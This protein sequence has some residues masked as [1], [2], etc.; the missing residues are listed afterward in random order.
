MVFLYLLTFL[1]TALSIF[2]LSNDFPS[3]R[4]LV[5][6][7]L[8]G[9]SLSWWQQKNN[10]KIPHLQTAAHLVLIFITIKALIPFFIDKPFDILSGLIKTWVYFLILASFIL[11][12]KRNFYLLQ[13]FS[14]GLVVFSCFSKTSQAIISLGYIMS[15]FILWILTLRSMSL[16]QDVKNIKDVVQTKRWMQ[17]ELIICITFIFLM[18]ILAIPVYLSIPRLNLPV[19]LL[20]RLVKQKYALTY[21]DFPKDTLVSFLSPSQEQATEKKKGPEGTKLDPSAL[22]GL[23][24]LSQEV[25]KPV[26]WHGPAKS[27]EGYKTIIT[28]LNE[29]IEELNKEI[30]K[31]NS[32]LSEIS[33]NEN[34][35]QLS[36]LMEERERL[37]NRKQGLS[38]TKNELQEERNALKKEF[39][40]QAK[41]QN[42]GSLNQLTEKTQLKHLE[43]QLE[44]VQ[45]EIQGV[46][47]KLRMIEENLQRAETGIE[48]VREN[49]NKQAKKNNI[50]R[51]VMELWAKKEALEE[52]MQSAKEA[53]ENLEAEYKLYQQLVKEGNVPAETESTS[54]QYEENIKEI[55]KRME[56]NNKQI[57]K[58]EEQLSVIGEQIQNPQLETLINK[59]NQVS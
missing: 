9:L 52:T 55:Q 58:I 22:E 33:E 15:F 34:L 5:F 3:L 40:E 49:V 46:I 57:A 17:R 42:L 38:K 10:K 44:S 47:N 48:E 37:L 31:A 6:F 13:F 18:I 56:E 59:I 41:I 51:Q 8:I 53:Q 25:I 12:T 50:H 20:F 14:L 21:I 27:P 2:S 4:A 11:Y 28:Q 26:F 43:Q 16:L 45:K 19:P 54:G 1:I 32:T 24:N 29:E 30:E 7:V 36:V 39:L 23:I 35:P